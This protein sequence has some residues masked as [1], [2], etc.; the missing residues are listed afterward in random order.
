MFHRS[1]AE[2][3]CEAG[4]S[5]IEVL[6]ALVIAAI[7]LVALLRGLGSSQVSSVYLESHLGARVLARSILE[8]ERQAPDTKAGR[9]TGDSGQYRWTFDVTPTQVGGIG[10]LQ[11]GYKIYRLNVEIVW[12]PRG[13]LVLDTL[14]LGK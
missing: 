8:D 1:A 10:K 3:K 12:N 5:L 4:F 7:A 2:P 11:N 13:R 6:T 9:R 14:K